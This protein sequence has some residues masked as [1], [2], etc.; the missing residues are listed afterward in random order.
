MT[1]LT[2]SRNLLLDVAPSASRTVTVISLCPEAFASGEICRLRAPAVPESVIPDSFT[3]AVLDDDSV[4]VRS[5]A[6]VSISVTLKPMAFVVV[7]SSVVCAAIA[8][9]SGAS[10]PEV[11]VTTNLRSV[12]PPAVSSTRT[13]I[14]EEPKALSAPASMTLRFLS[15]PVSVS[16]S[17]GITLPL[18]EVAVTCSCVATVST[19]SIVNAT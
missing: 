19:S 6:G 1:L 11:T 7:S 3:S 8:E 9:I 17:A 18:D 12:D 16:R 15:V 13:V 5:A 14:S 4:T 2:V 10:F